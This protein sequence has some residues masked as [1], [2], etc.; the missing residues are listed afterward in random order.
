MAYDIIDYRDEILNTRLE[1][2]DFSNP[3][4]DPQELSR[5]LL[6]TMRSRRGIGLS[7][8]QCGL[9]YRVFVMEGDPPFA[10]FNPK[11]VDVSQ[12][13]AT[14]N[15]GCLSYPGVFVPM[16][17]PGHIRVRFATPS[18]NI[19][20]KKFTGMTARVFQHELDHLDGVTFLKKMNPM[21]KERA[22]KQLKKFERNMKRNK[23]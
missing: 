12:E 16:K 2:F 15:E 19:V 6:E 22:L 4:I 3:P 1:L 11:I 20:T 21:H 17:R 14:L 5:N 7:A 10:C 9:P 23:G 8:N 18:G 13:L